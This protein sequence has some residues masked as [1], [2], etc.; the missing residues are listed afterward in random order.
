M[1]KDQDFNELRESESGWSERISISKIF[2]LPLNNGTGV[3][4]SSTDNLVN[5]TCIKR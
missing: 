1:K 5:T 4:I 2:E 3:Y